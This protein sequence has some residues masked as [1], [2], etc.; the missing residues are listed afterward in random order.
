MKTEIFQE[1][2]DIALEKAPALQPWPNYY[3]LRAK[4]LESFFSIYKP[5]SFGR[6]LDIGSGI[7]FNTFVLDRFY[8]K[9]FATDLYAEDLKTHSLGINRAKGFLARVPHKDINVVSCNCEKLA[10][11]G[12]YFD[13]AY[14]IYTL[15]HIRNRKKAL[16]EVFRVLKKDG[17]LVLLVPGV[18]E[19]VLYPLS[20]YIEFFKKGLS[21]VFKRRAASPDV[22]NR[23]K[24][25]IPAR[26]GS[27][28]QR[29]RSAYPHFPFPEPHGEYP[30][31]FVELAKTMPFVWFGLAQ[32]C[33]FR[34]K[35]VFTTMLFPKHFSSLFLGDKEL[36]FYIKTLWLNKKFGGMGFLKYLGQ[37][38]CIVMEKNN[39]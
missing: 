34:I 33:G 6:A 9:T 1:V 39:E 18:M 35:K 8:D 17:E 20:F 15:E 28:A 27:F 2:I 5:R 14:M 3:K 4:E 30:D 7:G 24:C 26:K 37:N 31:Y 16:N 19:R 11:K 13:T 36:D 25:G 32:S 22:G 21:Y 10:F 29:F 23:D 38:M 12:D